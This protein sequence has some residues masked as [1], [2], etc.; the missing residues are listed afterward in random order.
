MNFKLTINCNLYLAVNSTN[1]LYYIAQTSF[2]ILKEVSLM[3]KNVEKRTSV[4]D[5]PDGT[6]QT[7]LVRNNFFGNPED[8][9]VTDSKPIPM[10]S[11]LKN[12]KFHKK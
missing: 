8:G 10:E 11:T 7:E 3:K 5:T 1:L 2:I 12:S 9:V 6:D 4:T